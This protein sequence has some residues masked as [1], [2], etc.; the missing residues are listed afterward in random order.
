[1]MQQLDA[2]TATF[3]QE[4]TAEIK[5]RLNRT[6]EDIMAIGQALLDVKARL[7][8]GQ[9]MQWI[10]AEF[11]LS[12]DTASNWMLVA[13]KFEGKIGS[14]RNMPLEVIYALAGPRMPEPIIEQVI[15]GEIPPSLPAIR[16][17]KASFAPTPLYD[18]HT[19][20]LPD[21]LEFMAPHITEDPEVTAQRAGDDHMRRIMRAFQDFDDEFIA[22][23]IMASTD[24]QLDLYQSFAKSIHRMMAYLEEQIEIRRHTVLSVVGKR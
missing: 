15:A 21:G 9:F 24:E 2:E 19:E 13:K 4:K 11:D 6:L 10:E 5:A 18:P 17:A 22:E 12:H 16:E 3:V 23:F 7:P 14:L 8:H 20:P 1:M